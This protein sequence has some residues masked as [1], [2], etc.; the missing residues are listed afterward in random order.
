MPHE[1]LHWMTI[2][3]YF[4]LGFLPPLHQIP[5]AFRDVREMAYDL[6][7]LLS[8]GALVPSKT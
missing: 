6:S 1:Q 4:Y 2:L 7:E 3:S 8:C 5:E